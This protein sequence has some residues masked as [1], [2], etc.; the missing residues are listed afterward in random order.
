[1]N[2]TELIDMIMEQRPGYKKYEAE[3]AL[4]SVL[5]AIQT[6]L[7]DGDTVVLTGFGKFYTVDVPAHPVRNPQTGEMI[8]IAAHT[9]AKFRPGSLLKKLVDN[10]GAGHAED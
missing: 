3:T 10:G 8:T 2:R 5:D 1:M 4:Q 9:A 6:A 7:S